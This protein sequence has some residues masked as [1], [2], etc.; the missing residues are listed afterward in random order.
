MIAL[1]IAWNCLGY[2]LAAWCIAS[3]LFAGGFAFTMRHRRRA[4][5][6]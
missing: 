4:G 2:I 1:S 5:G 3:V 6:N